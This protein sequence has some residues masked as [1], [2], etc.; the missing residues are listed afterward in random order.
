MGE[1]I[2][3]QQYRLR[4]LAAERAASVPPSF[5]RRSLESS[6]SR[7]PAGKGRHE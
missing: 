6:M 2:D 5:I 1:V 7:H 3:M 4:K